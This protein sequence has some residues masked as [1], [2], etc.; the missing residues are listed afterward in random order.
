MYAKRQARERDVPALIPLARQ[1][2]ETAFPAIPPESASIEATIED[3]AV[4]EEGSNI[5]LQVL[6]FYGEPVGGF[7]GA[8]GGEYW[9]EDILTAH[10]IV[11][12]VH[13]KHRGREA[14][15]M[16]GDFEVW[17]RE[18]GAVMISVSRLEGVDPKVDLGLHKL[19]TRRDYAPHTVT[20]IKTL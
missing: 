5:Y 18:S 7:L 2:A 12:F 9:A 8:V 11:W 1:F 4:G 6:T 17:A 16:L 10:E 15:T 3:A 13:P 19:Y 20:Y 14:L